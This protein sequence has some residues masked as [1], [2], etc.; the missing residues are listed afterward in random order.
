VVS[1]FSAEVVVRRRRFSNPESGFAVLDCE[2]EGD[3]IVLVGPLAH[4]EERERVAVEG[5][6]VDDPRFGPQVKVR[7]ARP[8][9]PAGEAAL[10]AYLRRVKHVGAARATQLLDRYG[11]GAL[12]AIDADP[13]GAFA[14]LGLSPKRAREAVQSW[15][16][17]R[18]T[19][20]LHLLLAP[21]GLTWLVW[22]VH[23][24]YG[25]AAH[26][27]V[28]ERPYELTSLFGVGFHTADRIAR[29]AGVG[30]D[31]PERARAAVLHA[32]A[33]A[34]RDGSTCLPVPE[35]ARAVAGL[36]DGAPPTAGLLGEMDDHGDVVI[37]VD[38][39]GVV[40][41]YRRATWTLE[42]ELAK[43]VDA[44]LEAAPAKALSAPGD[45]GA[46]DL[47]PAPEQA[48]AVRAAFA[49][50]LSIVT[51][52]P[53]TGKTA[54]IRMICAAAEEQELDVLLVAPTG[55]AARRIAEA[56]EQPASTIHAALG[57]IP[58]EGPAHDEDSPLNADLLVVDETSMANLELLVTLLRATGPGMHVVL[59]GDADQLAPV[60][61]GKPFAEL[62]ASGR[63]PT[64]AL[65][66]IFRQA[67][68]S[69][70]VQGAHA[71][72][73]GEAPSF[74]A[75]DGMRRDLFL[76]ER[77]NAARALDE[78]VSLVASRLPEHYG[79]DPVEGIQVFAPVYKGPL[80]IDAINL[81][82]RDALNPHGEP[83]FGGRLR[84]GDKLML[85]GR[86]LH[87]L[88]LMN[89]TILRLLD[90]RG[91]GDALIVSA[92]GVIV[93]LPG[94][95]APRLGL[96]YACSVH[97]GQGIELPVAILVAHPAAGAFFLRREMLYTAMT[98]ARE[99][100]VVVGRREVVAR[101][102]RTP[103]T[104]RRHSRLAERLTDPSASSRTSG[105]SSTAT[106]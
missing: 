11:E 6:W 26:R 19:R 29:V 21:H 1:E 82:L 96:A 37:E 61:A 76:V 27:I 32:L 87:E 85:S 9:A 80:G 31:S 60:G 28:R 81:R 106:A 43:R 94:E 47:V 24:H 25:D 58:G 12:E 88:G 73:Q 14:G 72:R 101:A 64:A 63:V 79:V 48:E 54:T 18:A 90:V 30:A 13:R 70:I 8:L 66:H 22:R 39:D 7:D 56:T 78:I 92:D 103:D 93:T 51:G 95:E 69:M 15:D 105:S 34:E 75:T 71:V 84:I 17:L 67:A 41:C 53:G 99:A 104:A 5:A 59:V 42:A 57:W 50:R 35:L 77:D 16:G 46:Q 45:V 3:E 23:K 20:Q 62:V 2:H 74:A 97:K 65:Q 91:D 83:V 100:T 36:L 89:G 10:A 38:G 98:R 33:E 68:G 4:V 44:L 52:G 55:R 102:A 40:W 49:H 86:N